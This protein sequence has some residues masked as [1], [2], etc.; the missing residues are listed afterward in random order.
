MA[1]HVSYQSSIILNFCYTSWTT[2]IAHLNA[3]L[4]S[5]YLDNNNKDKDVSVYSVISYSA[6]LFDMMR[7]SWV[8]SGGEL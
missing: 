8:S 4:R 2:R 7:L 3:Q 5:F 1:N 6:S